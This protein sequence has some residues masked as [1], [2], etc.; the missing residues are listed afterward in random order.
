MG[1]THSKQQ[2]YGHEKV[3]NVQVHGDAAVCAQGV[4]Y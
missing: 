4:V 3:L 1:K 2:L